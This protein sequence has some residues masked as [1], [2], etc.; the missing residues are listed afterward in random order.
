[1]VSIAALLTTPKAASPT[2]KH[3][4]IY[5]NF[6]DLRI[7]DTHHYQQ[8]DLIRSGT[9]IFTNRLLRHVEHPYQLLVRPP[10]IGW[11]VG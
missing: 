6:M 8:N 9:Y 2:T 10:I 4:I 1:M 7:I 11:V 5:V 3:S